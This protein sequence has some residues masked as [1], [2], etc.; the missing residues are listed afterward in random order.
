MLYASTLLGWLILEE[1]T[2]VTFW[3]GSIFILIGFLLVIKEK[4]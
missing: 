4:K 3:I 2:G 1:N